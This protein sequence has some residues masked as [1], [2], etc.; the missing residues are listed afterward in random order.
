MGRKLIL[1]NAV[2]EVSLDL[3]LRANQTIVHR[4]DACSALF[5]ATLL[6]IS[7]KV[8]Q[9]GF[10]KPEACDN[11]SRWL[12]ARSARYHR[13]GIKIVYPAGVSPSVV[14]LWGKPKRRSISGGIVPPSRD[15]TTG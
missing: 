14:P 10:G 6:E 1:Q 12:S 9:V 15:S 3:T 4:E 13:K 2:V 7:A 11:R 8:D 5:S